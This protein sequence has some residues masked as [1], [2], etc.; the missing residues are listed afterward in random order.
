[1]LSINSLDALPFQKVC[2]NCHVTD[3]TIFLIGGV[4]N[5]YC[6][7]SMVQKLSF[8]RGSIGTN[9]ELM[10]LTI[11]GKWLEAIVHMTK[12]KFL[13]LPCSKQVQL[14]ISICIHSKFQSLTTFALISFQEDIQ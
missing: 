9:D 11:E 8:L 10:L 12:S 14:F 2:G 7:N 13:D 1:M 6:S 5:D 4:Y 3:F